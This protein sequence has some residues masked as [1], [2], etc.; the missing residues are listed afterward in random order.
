LERSA[1]K[2]GEVERMVVEGWICS[3]VVSIVARR[4]R[5]VEEDTRVWRAVWR[6]WDAV[7]EGDC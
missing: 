4:P 1:E 5:W 7:G 3:A 6:S 2:E